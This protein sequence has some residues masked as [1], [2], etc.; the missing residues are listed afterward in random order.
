MKFIQY[1]WNNGLFELKGVRG[2]IIFSAFLQKKATTDQIVVRLFVRSVLK[3][4]K[5]VFISLL[6]CYTYIIIN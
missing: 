3:D 5:T 2:A 4:V 1:R 6:Y